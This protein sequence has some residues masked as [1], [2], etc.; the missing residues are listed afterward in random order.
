M[1]NIEDRINDLDDK[2]VLN[3]VNHLTSAVLAHI[4]NVATA[5]DLPAQ[6][7]AVAREAGVSLMELDAKWVE[8]RVASQQAGRVSR[9]LL[10]V[11]ANDEQG[12]AFVSAAIDEFP[13]DDQDLG[14]LS[15]PIAAGLF[16]ISVVSDLDIDLGWFKLKKKGLSPDKQLELAKALLPDIFKGFFKAGAGST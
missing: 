8:A 5:A 16:Y 4:P 7:D 10:H 13:S 3:V 15:I 14:L 2:E 12:A 11:L 6:L 9:A 1:R